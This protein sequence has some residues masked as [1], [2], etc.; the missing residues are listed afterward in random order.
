MAMFA[1]ICVY[2]NYV[3]I[4]GISCL[5]VVKIETGNRE[6][7]DKGDQLESNCRC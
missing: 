6:G 2:K 1:I 3:N 4:W 5:T 7:R